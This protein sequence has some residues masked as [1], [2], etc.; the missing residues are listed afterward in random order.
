[1]FGG[2]NKVSVPVE[3]GVGHQVN[4][5]E[6]VSSDNHLMSE[7]GEGIH[8]PCLGVGYPDSVSGG[9]LPCDLSNEL[10][11]LIPCG[12]TYTCQNFTFPK[13]RLRVVMMDAGHT[14]L[15]C[16]SSFML[17]L[18]LIYNTNKYQMEYQ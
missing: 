12:Q 11:T 6:Q 3:E 14:S 18:T 1:M 17:K 10:D 16:P 5:F 9:N 15:R 2:Q 13:I 7:V 4:K 8:V